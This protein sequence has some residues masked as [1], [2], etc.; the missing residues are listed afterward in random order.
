MT[1][2]IYFGCSDSHTKKIRSDYFKEFQ[3]DKKMV[4]IEIL[5][6]Y[7]FK[8]H[9]FFT[10]AWSNIYLCRVYN[11]NDTLLLLDL[12]SEAPD[13]ISERKNSYYYI[14][15]RYKEKCPKEVIVTYPDS[16]KLSNTYKIFCGKIGYLKD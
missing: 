2:L 11:T 14:T 5:E 12:K 3:F 8:G 15:N 1:V 13:Y 7:P 16:F 4:S 10:K 6:Y 9:K